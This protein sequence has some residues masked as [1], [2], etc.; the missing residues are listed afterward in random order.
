MR[1]GIQKSILKQTNSLFHD[2]LKEMKDI[3]GG[4][5]S[6]EK[7]TVQMENGK[8]TIQLQA[9]KKDTDEPSV[10]ADYLSQVA[11]VTKHDDHVTMTL[12]FQSE[13]TITGFQV[14]EEDGELIEA[15]EKHV[16]PE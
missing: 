2:R 12:L 6:M 9:L 15:I 1:K 4:G 7:D 11:I 8:Y 16:D 10:M 13:K 5:Y 3:D 14:Q